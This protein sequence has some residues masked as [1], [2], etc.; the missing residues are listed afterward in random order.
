MRIRTRIHRSKLSSVLLVT[1][2]TCSVRDRD[3]E[4]GSTW[5]MAIS[6]QVRRSLGVKS[7]VRYGLIIWTSNCAHASA[8]KTRTESKSITYACAKTDTHYHKRARTH[9]YTC[10]HKYTWATTVP[11]ETLPI[12][13]LLTLPLPTAWWSN[14]WYCVYN[15][16]TLKSS[17]A[18]LLP[19][20]SRLLWQQTLYHDKYWI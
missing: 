10:T 5:I 12:I 18:R 7:G 19:K 8:K 1:N 16:S 20:W 17:Q 6:Q 3:E 9:T 13:V 15:S 2:R 4:T 14:N 11:G